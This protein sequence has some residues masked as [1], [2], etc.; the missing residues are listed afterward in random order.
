MRWRED[1]DLPGR[2]QGFLPPVVTQALVALALVLLAVGGRALVGLAFGNVVPFAL[3]FP[4][5]AVATLLAGSRSGLLVVLLGQLTT[6]YFVLPFHGS[7]RLAGPGDIASLV[8]STFAE[9]LL[10][11][12]VSTV[13]FQFLHCYFRFSTVIFLLFCS[14]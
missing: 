8:L 13:F 1:F 14:G 5:I 2:F 9:L 7:F 3:L 12:S 10:L 6:W 4:A 11:C